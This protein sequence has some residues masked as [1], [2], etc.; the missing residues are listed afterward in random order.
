[1]TRPALPVAGNA[2]VDPEGQATVPFNSWEQW[3]DG[4]VISLSIGVGAREPLPPG[5]IIV[6]GRPVVAYAKWLAWV[7]RSAAT[8][9][10]PSQRASLPPSNFPILGV[11]RKPT[12]PFFSWLRYVDRLLG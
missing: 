10:T 4:L 11:D 7:N 6:S 12:I 5:V 8:Y 2:L 3:I 1:M 9:G